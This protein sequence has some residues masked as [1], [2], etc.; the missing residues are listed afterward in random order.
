M[1]LMYYVHFLVCKHFPRSVIFAEPFFKT[2]DIL[3]FPPVVS[4][5]TTSVVGEADDVARHLAS[6]TADS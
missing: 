4:T 1:M 3:M 2:L 6:T 5:C